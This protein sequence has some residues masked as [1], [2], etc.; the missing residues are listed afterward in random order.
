MDTKHYRL[1]PTLVKANSEIE[2]LIQCL[3]DMLPVTQ[4]RDWHRTSRE[5]LG[6][7][8]D[9]PA[10]LTR[11]LIWIL[12]SESQRFGEAMPAAYAACLYE[13][14]L[15]GVEPTAD[16]WAVVVEKAT[17]AK[18]RL[19]DLLETAET[20][21]YASLRLDSTLVYADADAEAESRSHVAGIISG[22]AAA[23]RR[24][25][26][27]WVAAE[28]ARFAAREANTDDPQ[29]ASVCAADIAYDTVGVED[30]P[31]RERVARMTAQLIV[32]LEAGQ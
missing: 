5:A 29:R 26:G 15:A 16:E 24:A 9:V 31:W 2:N 4:R 25:K 30:G 1:V 18:I 12:R 28:I 8:A 21:W 32:A 19:Y 13:Q 20:A 27:R 10:A 11:W 6:G 7:C 23:K 17:E 22:C 3:G 14:R